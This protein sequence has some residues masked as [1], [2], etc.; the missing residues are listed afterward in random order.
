MVKL[1]SITLNGIVLNIDSPIIIND[2]EQLVITSD[3]K[4]LFKLPDEETLRLMV[5]IVAP[6][7]E[8]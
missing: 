8:K 6:E 1:E 2:G 3:G 5:H 4:I 7:L